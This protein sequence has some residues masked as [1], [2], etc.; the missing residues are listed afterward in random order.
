MLAL[1]TAAI[2]AGLSAV[3]ITSMK[4]LF[5]RYALARPN[6]RSSHVVPTGQGR[7]AAV[8]AAFLVAT[9]RVPA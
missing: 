7:G 8:L 9:A 2:G 3:L 6:A 5:A 1:V 4:P